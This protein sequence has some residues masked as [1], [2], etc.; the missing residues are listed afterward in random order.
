MIVQCGE[1]FLA[2][3]DIGATPT[4]LP[5]DIME[6]VIGEV[7]LDPGAMLHLR[8]HP[9]AHAESLALIPA[10]TQLT[11]DGIT[12]DTQWLR[13]TFDGQDGWIASQYVMLLLRG[14]LY[15]RAYVESL[16]PV[17]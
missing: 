3:V 11:I 2:F 16:L 4:P 7:D 10:R 15:Y 14:R 5:N 1:A 17:Y 12:K 8:R 6:G 9:D 13:A